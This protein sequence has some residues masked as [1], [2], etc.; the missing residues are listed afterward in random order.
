MHLLFESLAVINA[1]RLHTS[2]MVFH[3]NT[4]FRSILEDDFIPLASRAR[5]H[6]CLGKGVG[7]WLVVRPFICSFHITHF[8]F[9]SALCLHLGLIQ[10]L[11]SNLLTCECGHGLEIFGT[12][13]ACC[14]FG[15]QRI[16]THDAIQNVMYVFV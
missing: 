8:I 11:T 9:T 2:L 5:I 16:T 4:S 7:L 13:L 12:R 14:P 6:S 1:P 10:P 3:H 15:G